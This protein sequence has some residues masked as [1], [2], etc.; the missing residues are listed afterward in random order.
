[1]EV[2]ERNEIDNIKLCRAGIPDAF[3]DAGSTKVLYEKCSLYPAGIVNK[4]RKM[5]SH[6]LSLTGQERI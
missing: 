2:L 6:E 3:I 1:M 4:A 5:L